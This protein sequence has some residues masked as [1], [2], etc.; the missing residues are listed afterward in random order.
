MHSTISYLWKEP[1]AARPF[2]AAV[3]LHGHTNQSR[4]SL[5]F[6]PQYAAKHP[7]LERGLNYQQSRS[8][9]PVDFDKGYW[10]PPLPVRAALELEQRQIEDGLGLCSMVSLT[11]HDSIAAPMQLQVMPQVGPVPISLEWS[12]PFHGAVFHVG[13]H[14]LPAAAATS[15]VAQLN[16][17]TA[18]PEEKILRDLFAMLHRYAD[19]LVVLNHPLWDLGG[20][21]PDAHNHALSELLQ[22]FGIFLHALELNGVRNWQENQAVLKLCEGWNQLAVAG[23]DRHGCEPAACLNLTRARSFPEF[24]HEVR[25]ER[26]SDILFMPQ[27]AEPLGLRIFK[28][29]MDVIRYYPEYAEGSRHWDERVFHPDANGVERPL[30]SMWRKSPRFIEAIFWGLRGFEHA[31]VQKALH[32]ALATDPREQHLKLNLRKR[33]GV[34][35]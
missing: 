13:V 19:V 12:V 22:R 10:T 2:P 16:A 20:I 6:L 5:F 25:R 15:I 23:G 11:D 17:F 9:I 27:Y 4:E 3:C 24:V 7:W 35:S 31:A 14:N 34:L 29:L 33:E 1:A 26:R 32:A 8:P 30:S 18:A 21:G 28:T